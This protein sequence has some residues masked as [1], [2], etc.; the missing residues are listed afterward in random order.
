MSHTVSHL[1]LFYGILLINCCLLSSSARHLLLHRLLLRP[2]LAVFFPGSCSCTG[3]CCGSC[4]SR[5]CSLAK[6]YILRLNA[7]VSPNDLLTVIVLSCNKM[8]KQMK[9]Q[10]WWG[11]NSHSFYLC[12]RRCS[13]TMPE[14]AHHSNITCCKHKFQYQMLGHSH[15]LIIL[16]NE[17]SFNDH[18]LGG[19]GILVMT[20]FVQ[21]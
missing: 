17:L 7:P 16:F 20:N 14:H 9:R 18:K 11:L 3:S 10:S 1:E 19:R 12:L 8:E 2:L 6:G 5:C 13:E 4:L 21:Y 15:N